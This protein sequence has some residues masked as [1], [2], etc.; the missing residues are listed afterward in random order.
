MS[1]TFNDTVSSPPENVFAFEPYETISYTK[2]RGE[3][4]FLV[5]DGFAK[6]SLRWEGREKTIHIACPGDVIP[7]FPPP[8]DAQL[9][10]TAIGRTLVVFNGR[11]KFCPNLMTSD[12]YSSFFDFVGIGFSKWATRLWILESQS[13]RARVS[14]T[15]LGLRARRPQEERRHAPPVVKLDRKTLA[16]II[17]TSPETLSRVL[18]DLEGEGAIRRTGRT[19]SI[20]DEEKL[21]SAATS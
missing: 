14:A 6:I 5:L 8:P 13:V 7:S 11:S 2:E 19:I 9:A 15:L 21:V 18:T 17:C 3:G 1:A 10:T 20:L 12:E 4:F 16:E